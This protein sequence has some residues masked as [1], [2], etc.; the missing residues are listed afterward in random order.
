MNIPGI[1][2]YSHDPGTRSPRDG[3]LTAIMKE[4]RPAPHK[5]A[6]TF[7]AGAI[8]NCLKLT[9]VEFKNVP[10]PALYVHP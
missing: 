3:K 4:E 9:E 7:P 1:N 8:V 6:S 2:S 5:H 10:Q